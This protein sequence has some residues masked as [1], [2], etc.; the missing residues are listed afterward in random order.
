MSEEK[1]PQ[2]MQRFYSGDRW[3]PEESIGYLL[4]QTVSTLNRAAET[5]MRPHGLTAVQWAP[6]M[7]ISRGGNP[8]AASLARDLNTDTGAMTRMLDRLEAK[9]L[10]TRS[11]SSLDRRV[12]VLTLTDQGRDLTTRIPHH[13]AS[14]YNQHL[15]GF[16]ADEFQQLKQFLRRIIANRDH[17]GE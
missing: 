12:V 13:L 10:L 2:E 15:A 3:N 14:V 5:E 16:T 8:T 6:L 11:R 7:I 17:G 1:P 4:R 9:G